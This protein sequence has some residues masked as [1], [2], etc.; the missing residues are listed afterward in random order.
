MLQRRKN[1][2]KKEN[3][4]EAKTI[5]Y[6]QN[7]E[8]VEKTFESYQIG[9]L[10]KWSED[11]SETESRDYKG[12]IIDKSDSHFVTARRDYIEEEPEF[13]HWI[14]IA[15]AAYGKAIKLDN[16]FLEK[17]KGKINHEG[18]RDRFYLNGSAGR[19]SGKKYFRH[20]SMLSNKGL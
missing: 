14:G 1:K 4:L 6:G 16:F 17:E 11:Y 9:D 7:L 19:E 15:K 3:K 8:N 20:D 18:I 2:M 10:V 13:N 12:V 5:K